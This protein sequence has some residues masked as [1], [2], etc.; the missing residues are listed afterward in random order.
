MNEE[1]S[2]NGTSETG[3][4]EIGISETRIN[5]TET[6]I[7]RIEIGIDETETGINRTEIGINRTEIEINET[8]INDVSFSDSECDFDTLAIVPD[9][10]T[11]IGSIVPDTS[12]L[13]GP[14][15]HHHYEEEEGYDIDEWYDDTPAVVVSPVIQT[16]PSCS[17]QYEKC[18]YDSQPDHLMEDIVMTVSPQINEFDFQW[19]D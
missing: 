15:H 3:I 8:G 5:E 13:E 17:S 1:M 2:T 10:D 11:I 9:S 4:N 6:G 19:S 16:E 18:L 7:N 12:S 14:H